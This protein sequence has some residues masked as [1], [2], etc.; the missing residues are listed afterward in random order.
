MKVQDLKELTIDELSRK[1]DELKEEYFNLRFQT[2]LGGL[3]NPMRKRI[4][5]RTIA[6][7]NTILEEKRR[8]GKVNGKKTGEVKSGKDQNN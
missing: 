8:A 7:V 4:V 3:E 2:V 1:L 5:R 6:R